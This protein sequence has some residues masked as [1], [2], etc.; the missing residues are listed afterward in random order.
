MIFG[1]LDNAW[2]DLRSWLI[3]RF[4]EIHA[5]AEEIPASDPGS[6]AASEIPKLTRGREDRLD[7]F[8]ARLRLELGGRL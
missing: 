2:A 8:E 1:T 5:R 3:R 4:G 7:R 6:T